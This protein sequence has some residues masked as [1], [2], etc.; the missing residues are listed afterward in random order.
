MS[1]IFKDVKSAANE[2]SSLLSDSPTFA[3]YFYS[4]VINILLFFYLI[5]ILFY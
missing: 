3:D 1:S 4:I 2:A 5:N